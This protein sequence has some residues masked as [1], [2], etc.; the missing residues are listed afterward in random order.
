MIGLVLEIVVIGLIV[1]A[2]NA[3]TPIEPIFKR[4]VLILGVVIAILLVLSA[5]GVALP[6]PGVP[7]VNHG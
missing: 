2:V 1:W 7:K 4:I 3:W 6:S 5:F